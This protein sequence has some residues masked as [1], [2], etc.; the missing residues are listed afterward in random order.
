MLI[1][2]R[3]KLSFGN[4]MLGF[5][6]GDSDMVTGFRLVGLKGTEVASADEANRALQNA[7][8][9]SDVAIIVVSEEFSTQ[10]QMKREIENVRRERVSPLIIEIPS[11]KGQPTQVRLYDVVSRSLGV[12]M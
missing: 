9:R 8:G 12:M 5:V 11:P 3:I 7:L 2:Q 6:I 1:N 10:T 4:R